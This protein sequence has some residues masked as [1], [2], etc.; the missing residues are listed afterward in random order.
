[1]QWCALFFFH[2]SLF[3]GKILSHPKVHDNV[4]STFFISHD[5]L[6][7]S[8]WIIDGCVSWASIY[9]RLDSVFLSYLWQI[10][11]LNN[12][13]LCIPHILFDSGYRNLFVPLAD[14]FNYILPIR[15]TIETNSQHWYSFNL[16]SL[17]IFLSSIFKCSFLRKLNEFM[18]LQ[19]SKV[20]S[21]DT[22]LY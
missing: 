9:H 5:S 1:M 17:I 15:I 4:Y 11:A 13:N 10:V 2:I 8:P 14:F 3:L 21:H 19:L 6:I 16:G 22:K 18:E 12:G 20:K 7:K